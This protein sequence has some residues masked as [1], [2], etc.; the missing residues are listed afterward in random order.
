[1]IKTY[2]PKEVS[3]IIGTRPL[4]GLADGTFVTVRRNSDSWSLQIGADGEGV[5]SKTNDRSGQVE[6]VLQQGSSDNDF[7]SELANSDEVSN[8]GVVPILIKDNLGSSLFAA[9]SGWIKKPGDSAFAKET[10]DR[11]WL[12]E[13]AQLNMFIGGS[14]QQG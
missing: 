6:I 13:T 8:G 7:L 10:G 9:E 3:I 14:E 2:D 1:M 11:T 4:T 5:R 12:F